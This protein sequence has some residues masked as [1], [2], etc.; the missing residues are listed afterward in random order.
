MGRLRRLRFRV[1]FNVVDKIEN[2]DRIRI[3]SWANANPPSLYARLLL[4]RP[5]PGRRRS[6][7]PPEGTIK[8]PPSTTR[9]LAVIHLQPDLSRPPPIQM[10]PDLKRDKDIPTARYTP[11]SP[12]TRRVRSMSITRIVF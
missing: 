10:P 11:Q 9:P 8:K 1:T 7:G 6:P 5:N 12:G 2:D 3:T 4:A